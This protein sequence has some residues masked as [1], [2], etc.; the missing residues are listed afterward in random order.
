MTKELIELFI[1]RDLKMLKDFYLDDYKKI[2][3]WKDCEALKNY[4][5]GKKDAWGVAIDLLEYLEKKVKE[6]D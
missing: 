4:F 6:L 5:E 2:E 3:K 1:K